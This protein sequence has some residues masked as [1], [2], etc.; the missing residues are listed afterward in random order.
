MMIYDTMMM[1]WWSLIWWRFKVMIYD[2]IKTYWSQLC[3]VWLHAPG[4]SNSGI[5]IRL[6]MVNDQ[7]VERS[8]NTPRRC[9][10]TQRGTLS[11]FRLCPP[12]FYYDLNYYCDRHE[13]GTKNVTHTKCVKKRLPK[14]HITNISEQMYK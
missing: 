1:G 2:Y 8:E 14:E 4:R 12:G 13:K 11:H 9:R 6:Q 3:Q 10:N 7:T 5:R